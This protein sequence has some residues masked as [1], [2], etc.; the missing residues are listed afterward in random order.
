MLDYI[1]KQLKRELGFQIDWQKDYTIK[2]N[3]NCSTITQG[4]Q[5]FVTSQTYYQKN[6][7]VLQY[8]AASDFYFSDPFQVEEIE[9]EDQDEHLVQVKFYP[10]DLSEVEEIEDDD[11]ERLVHVKDSSEQQM[12]D[13]VYTFFQGKLYQIN[14]SG[15]NGGLITFELS[16]EEKTLEE[17]QF[18]ISKGGIDKIISFEVWKLLFMIK[19]SYGYLF[20]QINDQGLV[21]FGQQYYRGKIVAPYTISQADLEH[22]L[23]DWLPDN[24]CQKLPKAPFSASVKMGIQNLE[25]KDMFTPSNDDKIF[26]I[27]NNGGKCYVSDLN[28]HINH[29]PNVDCDMMGPYISSIEIYP[30]RYIL[31]TTPKFKQLMNDIKNSQKGNIVYGNGTLTIQPEDKNQPSITILLQD[32][33]Y[34]KD[35]LCRYQ[36]SQIV[37]Q[38]QS[39]SRDNEKYIIESDK[40]FYEEDLVA[41]IDSKAYFVIG[42]KPLNLKYA[43]R[44]SLEY[45]YEAN[46][47]SLASGQIYLRSLYNGDVKHIPV[48]EHKF[49]VR[50]FNSFAST[51]DFLTFFDAFFDPLEITMNWNN[52]EQHYE[53]NCYPATITIITINPFDIRCWETFQYLKQALSPK[54]YQLVECMLS[55]MDPDDCS[56]KTV[57]ITYKNDTFHVNAEPLQAIDLNRMQSSFIIA[58][59]DTANSSKPSIL[60]HALLPSAVVLG[61]IFVSTGVIA[62]PIFSIAL[63]TASALAAL[64][65][66]VAIYQNNTQNKGGMLQNPWV[67]HNSPAF[68]LALIAYLSLM[69]NPLAALIAVSTI[70][71]LAPLA[72]V[73]SQSLFAGNEPHI[74]DSGQ[75]LAA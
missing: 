34:F 61:A 36:D 43:F 4:D 54:A 65:L 37:T 57:E 59:T 31:H 20:M 46:D 13:M 48:D 41:S 56:D 10:E 51:A 52:H 26:S 5:T 21:V 16:K 15:M 69:T 75:K 18:I 60:P 58:K 67:S 63:M 12:S 55:M 17:G 35:P 66:Q 39:Q 74:A 70:M 24:F 11:Q 6:T 14:L 33:Y 23:A 64:A 38:L 53:F 32:L 68:G 72:S 25:G 1:I 62:M 42:G 7:A 73:M 22:H 3:Y 49:H 45:M 44:D 19:P 71:T 28:G 8:H 50:L 2:F 30:N 9:D 27:N 47:A 29:V 40:L